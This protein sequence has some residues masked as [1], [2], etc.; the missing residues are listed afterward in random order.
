MNSRP[1]RRTEPSNDHDSR[2]RVHLDPNFDADLAHE[3]ILQL[4]RA[5]ARSASDAEFDRQVELH[6][7]RG[8]ADDDEAG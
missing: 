2:I 4:V 3:R 7:K 8:R 1:L 5:L 6:R